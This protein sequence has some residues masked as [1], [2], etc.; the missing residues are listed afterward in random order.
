MG[1][2]TLFVGYFLLLNITFYG[3]TDVIAALIMAMGLYRLT[4]VNRDFKLAYY[5]S[6]GFAFY[7]FIELIKEFTV[8]FVPSIEGKLEGI[9]PYASMI[10]YA[11]ILALTFFMLKG[12]ANVSDEVGL[13]ELRARAN[14]FIPVSITVYALSALFE[15]P[16]LS[17]FI[18][19]E[20]L[21]II[22]AALW[23]ICFCLVIF[24][25][26]TVYTAYMRICMPGDEDM[27]K[28]D[29][30]SRFEFINKYR[31][32]KAEKEREY[33]E[34]QREKLKQKSEKKANNKKKK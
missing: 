27:D 6:L 2:G 23:V 12:I 10:R 13:R 14:L 17:K 33:L 29:S 30:P 22:S 9:V 4:T 26:I 25:L 3:F 11:I 16:L 15:I 18:P 28:K 34:Y 5:T 31:A 7:G 19:T 24:N 21:A 1:F 20:A 32:R 8:I